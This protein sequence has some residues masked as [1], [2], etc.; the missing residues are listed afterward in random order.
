MRL[1]LNQNCPKYWQI[2]D[3]IFTVVSAAML[4]AIVL[5]MVLSLRL[6]QPEIETMYKLGCSRLK[7]AELVTAEF[8]AI[9]LMSLILTAG[10]TV[11][12]LHWREAIIHR[13]LA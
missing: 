4:L 11:V 12:T 1:L 13:F 10:L 3:I 2:F 8:G 6:R 9:V 5:I 7:M